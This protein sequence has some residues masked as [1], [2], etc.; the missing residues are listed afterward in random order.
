MKADLSSLA[1]DAQ[2]YLKLERGASQP[3]DSVMFDWGED[4]TK[5]DDVKPPEVQATPKKGPHVSKL[6]PLPKI[7]QTLPS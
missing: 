4:V 3:Q 2:L 1:S 5:P 7:D 6:S